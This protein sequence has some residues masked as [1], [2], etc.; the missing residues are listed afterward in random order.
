MPTTHPDR[1]VDL[2]RLLVAVRKM[3]AS[4]K[5]YFARRSPI[6]LEESKHFERAVDQAIER[7]DAAQERLPGF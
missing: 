5:L 4:Q 3:R 2:E 7:L 6:D 1:I